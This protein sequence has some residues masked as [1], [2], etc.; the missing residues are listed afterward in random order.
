MLSL[1]YF[2]IQQNSVSP[3]LYVFCQILHSRKHFQLFKVAWNP[4]KFLGSAKHTANSD[5][6]QR[7]W[8]F[9]FYFSLK[10]G[11]NWNDFHHKFHWYFIWFMLNFYFEMDRVINLRNYKSVQHDLTLYEMLNVFEQQNTEYVHCTYITFELFFV[12]NYKT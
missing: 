1:F 9:P 8:K 6:W 5:N 10:I 11:Q 12:M 7:N 4:C 2:N 3:C